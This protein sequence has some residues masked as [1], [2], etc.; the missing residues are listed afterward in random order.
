[1]ARKVRRLNRLDGA[2]GRPHLLAM[3]N[4]TSSP[5]AKNARG[6]TGPGTTPAPKRAAPPRANG[7]QVAAPR[8]IHLTAEEIARRA[9]EIYEREG[10]QAGRELE[11]WLRAEAELRADAMTAAGG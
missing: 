7:K 1:M 4:T 11:N 2:E 8:P 10:R 5:S 9:Y 6:K 3:A